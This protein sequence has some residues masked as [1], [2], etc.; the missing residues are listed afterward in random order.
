V[1]CKAVL[2]ESLFNLFLLLEK[3]PEFVIS[4]LPF[5]KISNDRAPA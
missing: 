5:E 3:Y 1:L 2:F 4:F